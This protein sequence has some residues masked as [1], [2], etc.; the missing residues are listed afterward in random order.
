MKT[1]ELVLPLL[2]AL[3]FTMTVAGSA[4][5][6]QPRPA[7]KDGDTVRDTMLLMNGWQFRI[8]DPLSERAAMLPSARTWLTVQLPHTWNAID[9]A[10][11]HATAAYKRGVGSYRLEFDTPARGARHWLEFGAA[12][13]V[14]DVW[15]N[16]TLLGR[17]K[18]GFT[19][20]RFDATD[21]LSRGGTNVLIVRTDN[22]DATTFEDPTAIDPFGGDYN[23]SGGLYRHV[24]L[25]STNDPAHFS[26]GDLGGPGVYATTTRIAGAE[27]TVSVRA[28][29][30]NER[31]A[32][33]EFTV[34]VALLDTAGNRAGSAEEKVTLA[35]GDTGE[36]TQDLRVERVR[37]WNGMK[38]PYLYRLVAELVGSDGRTID[39]IERRFGVREMRFDPNDGFFLN[40][41][42]LRWHAVA[43]HQDFLGKSFAATNEDF[44][45]SLALVKEIG[46]NAVRLGHYPFPEYV[47][48][49]LD[50]MGIVAWAEK[51]TGIRTTPVSCEGTPTAEYMA[52]ARLQLREMIRQQYNHPSVATW[53]VGNETEAAHFSCP[54]MPDNVTPYLR[55]LHA[56]AKQED[57]SRASSNTE[58]SFGGGK[59][60]VGGSK[61]PFLTGGITDVL[62]TNRYFLWYDL[63]LSKLEPLL[64]G[65][66]EQFPKQAVG[67]TEY[68]AGA[69]IAHHTDN[70]LGGPPET[71]SADSGQVSFQP[72]EYQGYF[73]E[74]NYRVISGRPFLWGA[75][76][77]NLFDFGS[78]HRREGGLFGVN[79]KGLVTFDRLVKKDA[80][81]FYKAN[82]SSEPVTYITSR[83][84]TNRAYAVNDVR[85]YSNADTVELLVNGRRVASMNSSGCP[86]KVCVFNGVQLARGQNTVVAVGARGGTAV[87]D[88]VQW[89]FN[90]DGVN[91][92]AGRLTTG[93]RASDGATFGSDHYFTGGTGSYYMLGEDAYGTVPKIAG[94]RDPE[95]HEFLRMGEFSY[96]IPVEGARHR[97]TLGFIEPDSTIAEGGRVFNVLANGK[98]VIEGLD[99]RKETGG[100]RTALTRTFTADAAGGRLKLE[101]T[102]VKGEAAVVSFIT[103]RREP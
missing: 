86:M 82:W 62:G 19:Q 40:G 91:I 4:A 7:A 79:T 35:A 49:R 59:F 61:V 20:F 72:E 65:L 26:L 84:Y 16:D 15:L 37:R 29:L 45:K 48:D 102:P 77:W 103:V 8:D 66:H 10:S 68:G 52:N 88:S 43:M 97:V 101:F 60:L 47:L 81:Y 27:A 9:A 94:T 11:L 14:A 50:E 70:V 23:K 3:V 18:G 2:S 96:D 31:D 33:G 17:H 12:S 41:E 53:S 83:R 38:D 76:I 75:V 30:V 99:V 58:F 1:R 57:P 34:R 36:V 56:V 100:V 6:R 85:V 32:P 55:E 13:L 25:I 80:F 93:Y 5:A 74:Q 46:A 73:H 67:M 64:D 90:A 39:R 42:H 54:E 71:R 22:R 87:R 89:S 95:L 24:M 44:D 21:A 98:V 51:P 69:A 78:D 28:K 92:A 63:E